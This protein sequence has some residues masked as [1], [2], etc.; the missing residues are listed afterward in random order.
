MK[1]PSV[2][3]YLF[4]N[5]FLISTAHSQLPSFRSGLID[6]Q[7]GESG[8]VVMG[9]P[10]PVERGP[11]A[12]FRLGNGSIV[13]VHRRL[14]VGI[15]IVRYLANG[16]PDASF[17]VN[18]FVL[19]ENTADVLP[20]AAEIQADGDFVI[21][22][23]VFRGEKGWDG[24][25]LRVNS[26]G[27]FDSSFGN[28]GFIF[29][30]LSTESMA[31]EDEM[32]SVASFANGDVLVGGIASLSESGTSG[33]RYLSLIRFS[34]TG[35]PVSTF[36]NSG[37]VLASIGPG[38]NNNAGNVKLNILSNGMIVAGVSSSLIDS[39]GHRWT[40]RVF[41]FEPNGEPDL[42]FADGGMAEIAIANYSGFYRI[43]ELPNGRILCL[44]GP[45]QLTRLNANGSFDTTF[46]TNGKRFI[47]ELTPH[48]LFVLPSGKLLI[49]GYQG[50]QASSTA[51]VGRYWS[52]GTKDFRFGRSG[53]STLARPGHS[54]AF[55]PI[56]YE[57][58]S[59]VIIGG[60]VRNIE[61]S[62][63]MFQPTLS[64]MHLGK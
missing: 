52:D 2:A 61:H 42:A 33:V 6:R 27:T 30:D 4:A 32:T 28:G 59:S 29:F 23:S 47:T 58:Q 40:T 21:A 39:N 17:G 19:L 60:A 49:T 44:S 14:G 1:F 18:G 34:K 35:Q 54:L 25:V 63:W 36:G 12:F 15:G 41:R 57:N 24:F 64:R 37:R 62:Q 48:D 50:D 55:G 10:G 8:I 3:L 20:Y 5:L 45:T 7:F 56:L 16:T 53:L 26:D 11:I 38:F 9:A 46:G 13:N 22:G 43:I 51:A 31:S